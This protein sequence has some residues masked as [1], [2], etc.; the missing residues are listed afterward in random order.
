M[1]IAEFPIVMTINV[2]EVGLGKT[3]R[4]LFFSLIELIPE[5]NELTTSMLI[6][7]LSSSSREI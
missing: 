2:E 1:V 7:A 5:G 3:L 6:I 4:K